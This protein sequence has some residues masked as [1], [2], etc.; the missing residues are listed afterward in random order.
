[1]KIHVLVFTNAERPGPVTHE[2]LDIMKASAIKAGH[3][4]E[5]I[6]TRDCLLEFN[7][8]PQVLIKNK[9]LRNIDVLLVKANFRGS[10]LS[11]HISFIKQFEMAGVTVINNSRAVGRAK[12]KVRTL[13]RLNKHKIPIPKTYVI[14]SSEYID[15]VVKS[16]G[17]YPVIL[18]SVA[19]SQGV[20][21]SIV[22]SQRGLRSIIQMIGESEGVVSLMIQE[23]IK[24]SSGKDIRVIVVGDKI[25]A[26]MERIATRRG[27]FR[28]NFKLG[29]KVRIAE[30]TNK[31]KRI[32]IE[33]TKV[34]SLDFA[35]VDILRTK[36]GPKILEVNANPGLAGITQATKIDVGGAI[37]KYAA[38]AGMRSRKKKD[39]KRGR[40]V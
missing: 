15:K 18:K 36:T 34:C 29:G 24:E 21:V 39:E 1:M 40:R 26:A 7:T 37:V 31:E 32:A 5:I 11:Q 16:I 12:N 2:N 10:E 27:E 9:K 4:L 35:G 23:Y 6:S 17:S 38:K 28:S 33:A 3:E 19:G 30:L 25:V 8:K 13:Q 22:E 14:R 20:G